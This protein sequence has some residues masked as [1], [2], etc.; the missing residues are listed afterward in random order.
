M[1]PIFDQLWHKVLK[2]PYQAVCTQD[3]GTGTPVVLLHG[4]GSSSKVWEHLTAL[5]ETT[6][7]VLTFDLL[8]FGDSP[9][10]DWLD[11]TV[12]DHAHAVLAGLEKRNVTGPVVFVGHSM[13]CLVAVHIARLRPGF[14]KRLVL[15]EMPLYTEAPSLKR[16]T[17][18]RKLYFAVYK[19]ILKHP[20]YSPSNARM[21]QKLA[22]R[23]AGFEISKQTWTPFVKSLKNTVMNQTTAD[24][25]KRL[26]TPMDV[27]YGSRD[28]VVLRG[29]AQAIFGSEATHITTHI[30]ESRHNISPT[31]S[32][33]IAERVDAK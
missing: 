14:V 3:I 13:G 11:Y 4:L 6:H 20:K 15:Y 16:Y 10:P 21:V 5:L 25:M 17:M 9:K 18:L 28:R 31:A 12:D 24:D 32:A 23:V 27:I 1:Q 33:F 7:R 29:E 22:A 30:I 2:Q 19:R 8:G 26:S